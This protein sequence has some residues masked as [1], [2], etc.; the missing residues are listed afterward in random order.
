MTIRSLLEHVGVDTSGRDI[1]VGDRLVDPAPQP[2]SD[3][4]LFAGGAVLGAGAT[5][6]LVFLFL[7]WRE[8]RRR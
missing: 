4:L 6:Y 5:A 2:P 8:R 3:A 1:Y 7:V